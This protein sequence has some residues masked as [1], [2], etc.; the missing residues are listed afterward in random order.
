MVQSMD[1]ND[2]FKLLLHTPDFPDVP[3]IAFMSDSYPASFF[4]RLIAL[5]KTKT[6]C[7]SLDSE[8]YKL[9]DIKAQLETSF[10]G[11]RMLYLVKNIHELD[12][13]S[14]R[15]WISYSKTYQGPHC[16]LFFT[17]AN[18][19]NDRMLTVELPQFCDAMLY[20]L[21]YEYFY[22]GAQLD[23]SFV[24]KLFEHSQKITLDQACMLMGYQTVIGRKSDTFFKHWLARL[25]VPEKSLFTLSQYLFAKQPRLFL[26]HW[27]TLKSDFPE[28]F[29]VAYWSEQIWQAAL[30]VARARTQ[31]FDAAKKAAYRLPFS[32][33]NK[34]WRSH[35]QESL[36]Q[37]HQFLYKLDYN[38]KNSAGTH[39]LELWHHTFLRK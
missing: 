27:Q 14:K 3:G 13:A 25:V 12:A 17:Q 36:T 8:L 33:I 24:A 19:E 2:F 37:A 15:A 34:D 6:A 10:L 21:L 18:V 30:F 26:Q 38:L 16:I 9:A 29:W 22:E 32:F 20:R 23:S 31:G 4:V 39:G 28:E 1:L 5:L 11:N 35:S 7:M